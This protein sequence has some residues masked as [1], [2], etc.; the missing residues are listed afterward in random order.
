MHLPLLG[1][2]EYPTFMDIPYLA[3]QLIIIGECGEKYEYS[4]KM[5]DVQR[6]VLLPNRDCT[7]FDGHDAIHF[8]PGWDHLHDETREPLTSIREPRKTT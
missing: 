8:Q 6:I 1:E 4:F 3:K 2:V 5:G 7:S